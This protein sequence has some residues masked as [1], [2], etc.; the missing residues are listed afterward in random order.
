M[1]VLLTGE[2]G[3]GKEL[4]ARA[5]HER[6]GRRHRAFVA[7]NCSA[8]PEGLLET[9]LFGHRRGA[10]TGAFRDKKGLFEEAADGTV[11]LDEIGDMALAVQ[12]RL[13][14][15]L[16]D[17]ELRRVGDTRSK[18]ID[19]R[20][21]G[22]TN[23][24]LVEECAR[25]RFRQDLYFRLAVARRHLPSLRE[26]PEDID[27][28]VRCFLGHAA[29][30]AGK[31]AF[32]ITAGALTLLRTYRWPGNVRELRNTIEYAVTATAGDQIVEQTIAAGLSY[33]SESAPGTGSD[34]EAQRTVAALQENRWNRTRTAR[35]LGINRTTLW[36]RLRKYGIE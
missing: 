2:T 17:G 7:I 1:P 21:I 16:E 18:H 9:E 22:A 31:R 19:V 6:S 8:I 13:L 10:F 30:A 35:L 12:S 15:F 36:R 23:R 3:T 33:A 28:L 11:F 32:D 29:A 24:S 14:R 4:V 26:R 34:V 5:L 27:V 25:G 20:I